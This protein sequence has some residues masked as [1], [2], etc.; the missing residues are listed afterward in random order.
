MSSTIIPKIKYM[1]GVDHQA[2]R[3]QMIFIQSCHFIIGKDKGEQ[4]GWQ[5]LDID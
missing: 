4:T 1:A 3:W 2:G 5:F